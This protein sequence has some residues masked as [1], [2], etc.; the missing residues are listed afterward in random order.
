MCVFVC[1]GGW[2][3][4]AV[5]MGVHASVAVC[6]CVLVCERE[7]FAPLCIFLSVL[8]ALKFGYQEPN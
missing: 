3:G 7:D 8:R 6:V 4:L 2:G 5:C 1:G